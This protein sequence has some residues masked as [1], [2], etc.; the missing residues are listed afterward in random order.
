MCFHSPEGYLRSGLLSAWKRSP[1]RT[2]QKRRQSG[3]PTQHRSPR[4]AQG[5]G[6]AKLPA[7]S[8]LRGCGR[9]PRRVLGRQSN[10]CGFLCVRCGAHKARRDGKERTCLCGKGVGTHN[11]A[12]GCV[13]KWLTV[14]CKE[15]LSGKINAS[16][17]PFRESGEHPRHKAWQKFFHPRHKP[18]HFHTRRGLR[19]IVIGCGSYADGSKGRR[20]LH[21]CWGWPQTPRCFASLL[22]SARLRCFCLH[23]TQ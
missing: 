10:L 18:P 20:P 7:A 22:P 23:S 11:F 19:M 13:S 21:P 14:P 3:R 2:S 6:Y 12:S 8:V 1:H 16:R 17:V 4:T 15:N 9:P 5:K